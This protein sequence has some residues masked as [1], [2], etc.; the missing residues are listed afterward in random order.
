[1]PVLVSHDYFEP[2]DAMV[3][4]CSDVLRGTEELDRQIR[5]W[6]K[7]HSEENEAGNC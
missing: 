7:N 1:M 4:L 3:E 2:R 6:E 5:E